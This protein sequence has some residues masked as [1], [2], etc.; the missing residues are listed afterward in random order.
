M[1]DATPAGHHRKR[2]FPIRFINTN[3]NPPQYSSLSR[4]RVTM[5]TLLATLSS[6]DE[7]PEI[8]GD[9]DEGSDSEVEMEESFQF[10]GILVR[11]LVCIVGVPGFV[12]GQ[13]SCTKKKKND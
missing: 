13:K 2:N 11:L 8:D 9:H 7:G 4:R 12:A 5:A 3:T 10:G 1:T 6:D